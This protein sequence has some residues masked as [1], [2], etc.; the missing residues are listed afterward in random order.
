MTSRTRTARG[1]ARVVALL[2]ATTAV[3]AAG[4]S[5]A[6]ARWHLHNDADV[7]RITPP[8]AGEEGQTCTHT[9]RGQSGWNEAVVDP[10]SVTP[11]PYAFGSVP[12]E[13]YQAGT[14]AQPGG[15]FDS[16]DDVTVVYEN[17]D[18]T[19]APADDIVNFPSGPR[20]LLMP[21]QPI[22]P[23][24]PPPEPSNYVFTAG[25]FTVALPSRVVA[26]SILGV[27]P[28]NGGFEF[29]RLTAVDC[30]RARID[31]L[32]GVSPNYVVP[33]VRAPVLPVLVYGSPTLHVR[34]VAT[35][36]VRLG[37]AAPSAVPA[38]LTRPFDANHDGA[39]DRVYFFS[40]AA[41]GITCGQTTVTLVGRTRAGTHFSG[42][43]AIRTVCR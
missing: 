33:A 32:P 36:S 16:P 12:Y 28:S 18:G 34:S 21:P 37:N 41:T 10:T 2:L 29:L 42:T 26:G 25:S 13:V 24:S 20:H 9:L 11:P 17:P 27:K 30:V 38:A 4:A 8:P 23:P 14:G 3:T 39:L 35:A 6:F 1:V 40:P 43:D 19:T 5:T 15:F 22:D 31:V 7:T